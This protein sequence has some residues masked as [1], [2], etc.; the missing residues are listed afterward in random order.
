M[1][2]VLR[3]FRTV[4]KGLLRRGANTRARDQADDKSRR[5]WLTYLGTGGHW[6]RIPPA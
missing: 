5:R 1:R 4:L 2:R 6:V 3:F